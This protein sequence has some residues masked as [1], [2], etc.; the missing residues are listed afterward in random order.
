MFLCYNVQKQRPILAKEGV[1]S[2]PQT[3]RHAV[4]HKE[5]PAKPFGSTGSAMVEISA[6]VQRGVEFSPAGSV[7]VGSACHRHAF[8]TDPF[9]SLHI[10][11][12]AKG[13]HEGCLLL[14]V[15]IGITKSNNIFMNEQNHFDLL[16]FLITPP[17]WH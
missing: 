16:L 14:L 6:Q 12:K 8:T 5:K 13:T 11:A 9:D 4:E 1:S 15:E 7:R 3:S 17:H 10:N 2:T